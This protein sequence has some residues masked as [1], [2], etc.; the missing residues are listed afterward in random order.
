MPGPESFL[1]SP[2]DLKHHGHRTIDWVANYLTNL[3]GYAVLAKTAP[4]EIAAMLPA[5]CPGGAR[6]I[7]GASRRRRPDRVAGHHPLAVA[8]LLRLLSRERVTAGDSRRARRGRAW[9]QRDGVGDEPRLHG[10]RDRRAGLARRAAGP[11]C[12]VPFGIARRWRDP[13][14][15]LVRDAVRLAC[16]AGAGDERRA[17]PWRTCVCT[18][19][20]RPIL[21]CKRVLG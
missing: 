3:D 16:R 19:R 10:D 14:Q 4:G 5:I 20:S 15:C 2:E 9:C 1:V 11:A 21:P 7:R 17:R 8:R 12:P 6:A 13:R 18:R